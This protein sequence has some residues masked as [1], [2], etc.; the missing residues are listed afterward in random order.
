LKVT[1][2]LF[3]PF[4]GA[5]AWLRFDGIVRPLEG[6]ERIAGLCYETYD[7]MAEQQLLALANQATSEFEL[8]AVLVEHSRGFGPSGACS[9]R[10]QVARLAGIQAAK[11]TDELIPLCHSLPLDSV[12]VRATLATEQNTNY[13]Q[14]WAEA[15]TTACLPDDRDMLSA[16]LRTWSEESPK[17]DLILTAGGTG[18]SPRDHTP[19]A[20][21]DVIERRHSGLMELIRRRCYDQTPKAYLS[22]GEAGTIGSTLVIN[23][24]G[25]YRGATDA[26]AVCSDLPANGGAY[27]RIKAT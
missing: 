13:V 15:R 3:G 9:F 20:T 25:S 18:L 24:P 26:W 6:D 4:P 2:L 27:S 5:G 21:L 19:E 14:L 22:R 8:M 16:K 1:I 12:D 17:P 7:P 23:L 11:R 10:L